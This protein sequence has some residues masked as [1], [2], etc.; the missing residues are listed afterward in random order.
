MWRR[1]RVLLVIWGQLRLGLRHVRL[2]PLLVLSTKLVF[3]AFGERTWAE[4]YRHG[5]SS[6]IRKSQR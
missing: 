5:V 1:H 3:V 4:R 2:H 6:S